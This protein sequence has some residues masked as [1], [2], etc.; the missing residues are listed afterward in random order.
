MFLLQQKAFSFF[1]KT[2]LG[3]I[4]FIL[5]RLFQILQHKRE[6]K[7]EISIGIFFC[8]LMLSQDL[9]RLI[10]F[11]RMPWE[12]SSSRG[13]RG[14]NSKA[15]LRTAASLPSFCLTSFFRALTLFSNGE[16]TPVSVQEQLTPYS[17]R[18]RAEVRGVGR[19]QGN[20][21]SQE[22]IRHLFFSVGSA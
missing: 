7:G 16:L 12:I 9:L 11:Y 15:I 5:L 1:F 10:Y 18:A 3:P 22:S 6:N 2:F 13:V 14:Y 8:S 19:E 17:S 20:A 4:I 21:N